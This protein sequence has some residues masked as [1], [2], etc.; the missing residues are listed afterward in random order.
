MTPAFLSLCLC[1][2]VLVCM[3]ANN[4]MACNE[5]EVIPML[6]ATLT[7]LITT[8]KTEEKPC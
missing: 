6:E 2:G 4:S 3:L 1:R 7:G 5:A 8:I